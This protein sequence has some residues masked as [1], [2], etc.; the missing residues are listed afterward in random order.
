MSGALSDELPLAARAYLCEFLRERYRCEV[1]EV[2]VGTV[3]LTREVGSCKLRVEYTMPTEATFKASE[4]MHPRDFIEAFTRD[5][6]ACFA[7]AETVERLEAERKQ[8]AERLER[9][10]SAIDVLLSER[11]DSQ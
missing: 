4:I 8:M 7:P 3:L 9:V 6:D 10:Q 11:G 2:S 5:L 1:K